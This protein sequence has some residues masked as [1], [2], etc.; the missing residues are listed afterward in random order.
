MSVRRFD[1]AL[2]RLRQFMG[3]SFRFGIEKERKKKE[4]KKSEER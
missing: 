4:R 3:H 2:G 1:E